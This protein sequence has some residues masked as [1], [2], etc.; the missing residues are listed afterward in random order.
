MLG[1]LTPNQFQ[2]WQAY[3]D[4][5]AETDDQLNMATMTALI[6]NELRHLRY[7]VASFMTKDAKPDKPL[8]PKDLLRKW[9]PN[10]GKQKAKVM[11]AAELLMMFKQHG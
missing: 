2:E 4:G 9:R 8:H 11:S 7:T 1:E 10:E 3:L 5:I 6:V